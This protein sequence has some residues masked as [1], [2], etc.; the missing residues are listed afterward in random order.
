MYTDRGDG[1]DLFIFEIDIPFFV[2]M[3]REIIG[4]IYHTEEIIPKVVCDQMQISTFSL[5]S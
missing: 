1:L 2:G 4:K 5:I 3:D